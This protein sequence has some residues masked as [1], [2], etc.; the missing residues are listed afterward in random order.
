MK[1]VAVCA[2]KKFQDQAYAFIR[3]LEKL[4]ILVYDPNIKEPIQEDKKFPSKH[5]TDT[6]FRGLTLE[7]FDKLRKADVC[8]LFNYNDY[9]GVS[10]TLELGFACALSKPIYALSEKTGDPCRDVLIDRTAKTPEELV[11]LLK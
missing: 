2:S 11:K 10:M 4:G 1:T 7:H 6:I 3:Q 9:M 8:Y 5:I